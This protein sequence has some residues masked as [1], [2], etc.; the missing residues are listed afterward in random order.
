MLLF[1]A[2]FITDKIVFGPLNLKSFFHK[3]MMKIP[4]SNI[5]FGNGFYPIE[6]PSY[7]EGYP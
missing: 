3:L 2:T 5:L 6:L 1:K 4:L 7:R